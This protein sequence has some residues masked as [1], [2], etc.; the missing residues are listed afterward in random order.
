MP[1]VTLAVA[2]AG[3]R[4][5]IYARRAHAT[6]TAVVAVAEP[7][8]VRRARFAAEFGIAPARTFADWRDLAGIGRIADGIVIATQDSEHA[9]PAVRFAGLGY[10]I[11][12]EKP[13]APDEADSVRIVEAVEHAGTMLA[14]CHVLRYMP[15]TRKLREL[16]GQG[17]IGEPISIQHLEPIGWWHYAHSYVRGN[18]RR[19]DT[20]G[21]MLLTKS[22]HDI[23]WISYVMGETPVRVSSFGRRSHFRAEQ[24]PAGATDRCVSCPVEPDCPYSAPRLYLSC[25]GDPRREAWPLGA[26]THDVTRAGVLAALAD[27]PYGRCVYASD[28]DVV[29][30]QVVN[31][32]FGSGRTGS[33]T[34]T[35]F[36]PLAQRQTRLFGTHGAIEGD[37]R[38]LTVHDFVSGQVETIETA[39]ADEELHGHGGGDEA[40]T[41]AFVSAI[42]TGDPSLLGSDARHALAGHR[43]VWA[44]E[45]ARRTGTVVDIAPTTPRKGD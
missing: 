12:L 36:T 20:S 9:E 14:V 28:N 41:D 42:A 45:Q 19:T 39:G 3:L 25:L 2:G 24:R 30:H 40:L 34:V 8:P 22:C 37:G 16:V 18:W 27:G 32:E 6:G 11:L 33:F 21:P 26:V 35:A 43:V 10:H 38:R 13:M 44:A 4:G 31:L 5:T 23:D 29:D 17:R 7:D 15:Y 1:E